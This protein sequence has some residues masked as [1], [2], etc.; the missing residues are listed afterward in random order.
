MQTRYVETSS[1]A[2]CR[3][4][5]DLDIPL[6]VDEDGRPKGLAVRSGLQAER[7]RED[8]RSPANPRQSS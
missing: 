2:A 5:A 4:T 8:L 6:L 1:P 7:V 3:E